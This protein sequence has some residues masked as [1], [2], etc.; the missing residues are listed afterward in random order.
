MD[1]QNVLCKCL[2]LLLLQQQ[3]TKQNKMKQNLKT[4]TMICQTMGKLLKHDMPVYV[5]SLLH[6]NKDANE[7]TKGN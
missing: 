3:A 6:P 1:L 2:H 7:A 5:W 4:Q